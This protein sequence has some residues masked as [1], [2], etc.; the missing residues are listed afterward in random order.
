[1]KARRIE[2][3]VI[4]LTMNVTNEAEDTV[5]QVPVSAQDL[6]IAA[7]FDSFGRGFT[8]EELDQRFPIS[9]IIREAKESALLSEEDWTLLDKQ[10]TNHRWL[11]NHEDICRVRDAIKNAEKVPVKEAGEIKVED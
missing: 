10:M 5:E 1:M 3:P 4:A 9:K 8:A 7:L 11:W 6:M 2:F